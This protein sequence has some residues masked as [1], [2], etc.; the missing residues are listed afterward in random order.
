MKKPW[1]VTTTLRNP[2]RL[3][4]FLIVLKN[5]DGE[6]WNL[7]TQKKYQILLIKYRKYGYGSRQFYNGLS[8]KQINLI[9]DL[10]K[11]ISFREAEDIFN[12]KGY[13]DPAMRG[14]QSINPLK[15]LGLVSIK[16][17]KV[18]IADLGHLLLKDDYDL[19][20]MFFR[21]FIKWQIPNLDNDD[22][23]LADGYDIKPFIGTLHLINTVNKKTIVNGEEPKGIS[24]QEFSLFVPTLVS[25]KNIEKYADEIIK[26]RTELKGKNKQEHKRTFEKYKKQFVRNF[27]GSKNTREIEK[28]SNNLKDYGDNAIRYFRLTRYLYIRGNG[29]YVDLEQRRQVEIKNLLAFD[30]GKS[31]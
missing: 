4:D 14:R 24:K 18:C 2:E 25:Y 3:R 5:I 30:S 1:S 7:E 21:S 29:F 19:G 8:P 27:L 31:L 13:E 12:T 16:E 9:N 22:Y 10:N 6:V 17:G 15:K 28:L 11:E 23:R 20:E 26:L